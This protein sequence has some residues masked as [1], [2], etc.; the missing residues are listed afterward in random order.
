MYL[1]SDRRPTSVRRVSNSPVQGVPNDTATAKIRT[2]HDQNGG[3]AMN[4]DHSHI[5]PELLPR[6]L[7]LIIKHIIGYSRLKETE[8]TLL[9]QLQNRIH[10]LSHV[11]DDGAFDPPSSTAVA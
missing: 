9:V 8:S 4:E 1:N 10:P 3:V 7:D 2:G 5:D 11:D 6:L